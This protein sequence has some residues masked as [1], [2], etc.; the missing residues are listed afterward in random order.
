MTTRFTISH[1]SQ[2]PL[3]LLQYEFIFQFSALLASFEHLAPKFL[4]TRANQIHK[5][6]SHHRFGHPLRNIPQLMNDNTKADDLYKIESSIIHIHVLLCHISTPTNR[7]AAYLLWNDNSL[8]TFDDLCRPFFA[9]IVNW[10]IFFINYT[11]SVYSKGK[12][13]ALISA[14]QR[15]IFV[16]VYIIERTRVGTQGK[17]YE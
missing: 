10:L 5:K 14:N 9:V 2:Q 4:P 17:A 13:R 12:K 6:L 16:R 11:F 15:T 7:H 1:F 8:N 3:R